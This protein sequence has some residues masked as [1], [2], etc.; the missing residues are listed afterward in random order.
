MDHFI[1]AKVK[2]KVDVNGTEP[3]F[4]GRF[5]TVLVY[6]GLPI[7]H[8]IFN[9]KSRYKSGP[10]TVFRF[11]LYEGNNYFGIDEASGKIHLKAKLPKSSIDDGKI[12]RQNL[13]ILV[14][15]ATGFKIVAWKAVVTVIRLPTFPGSGVL[16]KEMLDDVSREIS[17]DIGVFTNR[18]RFS[19]K[20]KK[21][22]VTHF[23]LHRLFRMPSES[24]RKISKAKLFFD[25]VLQKVQEEVKRTFGCE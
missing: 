18:A 11:Q 13:S 6:H 14:H 22:V 19:S 3:D 24:A 25:T 2:V 1:A 17:K 5:F 12:W 16:T 4:S 21:E 23:G 9:L 7:D 8:I 10:D 20:R 15:R